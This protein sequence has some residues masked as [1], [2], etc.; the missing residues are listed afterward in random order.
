MSKLTTALLLGTALFAPATAFAKDVTVDVGMVRFSGNPAYLAVYVT[1]P[2]GSYNSTLWVSAS[3]SRYLGHLRQWAQGAS[4][5]GV[6]LDG[7][8]G[9]SVGGGKTLTVHASIADALI[10]AGYEVH[11]D[12]AVENGGEYS[13][14]AVAP[15]T[16][17]GVGTPVDGAGYISKLT[18]SF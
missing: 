12:S 6:K 5:V 14:D 3:K 8:T 18:V 10:D 2:D 4:A 16:T 7:I 13:S 17:A 11:V 1:N 15:L 9:A